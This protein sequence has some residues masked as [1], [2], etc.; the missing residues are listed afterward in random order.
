M[1]HSK[2]IEDSQKNL[3]TDKYSMFGDDP[4]SLSWNDADSQNL[5]FAKIS[6]LFRYESN[7]KFSVHEIGCGLGHFKQ[8]LNDSGYGCEYSGSDII[9][10]FINCNI[11]KYPD[12][13]FAV[14]NI[15][16]DLDRI[17]DKIK[18]KDYYCLSGTFHT[19]ENNSIEDWE[20]FVFKSIQNMFEMANKGIGFNFLTSHSDFYDDGLYYANPANILDWSIKNLSRF[21]SISHD[22][23]L[24]EFTVCAY[25]EDFIKGKFPSYRKYF[26]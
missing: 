16:N 1:T 22:M 12:C 18:G 13:H 17:D 26:G 7:D 8:Y 19:I 24:Y 11:N 2:N 5:R 15:S 14:Q 6:E 4:K 25:K 9:E 10:D 3:Y 20:T 23:P 21:V